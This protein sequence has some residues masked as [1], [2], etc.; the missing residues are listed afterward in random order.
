MKNGKTDFHLT[1][2]SPKY[3]TWAWSIARSQGVSFLGDFQGAT[4]VG[5]VEEHLARRQ[6]MDE[7]TFGGGCPHWSPPRWCWPDWQCFQSFLR[8]THPFHLISV[9]MDRRSSS[10]LCEGPVWK[11]NSR[12]IRA[13]RKNKQERRGRALCCW[14]LKGADVS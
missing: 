1:S 11:S 9:I 2:S 6:K 14:S 3:K 13:E 12:V 5:W 10:S 4:P 8:L 7:M